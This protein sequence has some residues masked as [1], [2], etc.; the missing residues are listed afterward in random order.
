M[1]P[2]VRMDL[3]DH[4]SH[5]SSG[6]AITYCLRRISVVPGIK[7][8]VRHTLLFSVAFSVILGTGWVPKF[9]EQRP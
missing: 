1:I 9:L 3:M 4:R 8:D 5:L 6:C 7:P 2:R